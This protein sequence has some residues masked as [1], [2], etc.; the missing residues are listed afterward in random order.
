MLPLIFLHDNAEQLTLSHIV[1]HSLTYEIRSK[2]YLQKLVF[3]NRK[4]DEVIC[5]FN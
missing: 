4:D 5:S 3:F 1:L 2:L